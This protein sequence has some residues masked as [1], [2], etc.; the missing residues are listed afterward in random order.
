MLVLGS[1]NFLPLNVAG[2]VENPVTISN[3]GSATDVKPGDPLAHDI[4]ISIV[5]MH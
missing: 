5:A 1:A 4:G 2:A 3:A